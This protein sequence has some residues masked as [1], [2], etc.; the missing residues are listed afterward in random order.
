MGPDRLSERWLVDI[1][2]L[3]P[4]AGT[5]RWAAEGELLQRGWREPHRRY[6][7]PQ[8]LAEVF[9]ALDELHQAGAVDTGGARVA[10][11]AGWYHDLAYDTRA[12]PG[13]NEQRSAT[14][15]RDHLHRLGVANDVVDLVETLVLMTADHQRPPGEPATPHT[16]VVEA[17]HDADLWI[18]AAAPDRFDDYCAQVR[19]EYAQVPAEAYAAARAGILR[20][21]V[22]RGPVYRTAHAD[23]HWQ[24]RAVD[25]V[26]RELNRLG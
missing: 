17:F 4:H 15:A 12:A 19:A 9:A 10:R 11:V 7:T 22:G 5:E 16:Q 20:S 8:H 21:L 25:N 13:S 2:A 26:A 6:H 23:A 24:P 1:A 18:L 14:L 3:A